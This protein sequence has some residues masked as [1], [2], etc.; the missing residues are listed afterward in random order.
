MLTEG[1]IDHG[2]L[3]L[4]TWPLFGTL[5]L[6]KT[7]PSDPR[8][9]FKPRLLFEPGFYTDI[10]STHIGVFASNSRNDLATQT[11]A[12]CSGLEEEMAGV[13]H[14]L[15]LQLH[16]VLPSVVIILELLCV[17]LVIEILDC[18]LRC[19]VCTKSGIQPG[20]SQLPSNTFILLCS[21]LLSLWHHRML[22]LHHI[23]LFYCDYQCHCSVIVNAY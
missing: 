13:L 2:K 4:G 8:P 20:L 5:P 18:R 9:L 6:L 22:I 21:R 1:H 15:L 17:S 19:F 3:L 12:L 10:Y 16:Y 11:I 7:C 23:P 14:L